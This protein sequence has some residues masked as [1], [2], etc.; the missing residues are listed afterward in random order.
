L[1]YSVAEQFVGDAE[2]LLNELNADPNQPERDGWSP[3]MFAANS[4]N[5]DMV[6]LLLRAGADA[7][8]IS[9]N[10]LRA[11]D[12]VSCYLVLLSPR[13]SIQVLFKLLMIWHDYEG[14]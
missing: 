4:G 7:N 14:S 6:T 10:G 1:I 8:H 13:H 2:I 5:V 12:L 11:L 3:L 9:S